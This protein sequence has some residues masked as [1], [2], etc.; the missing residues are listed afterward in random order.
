MMN[1]E[2]KTRNFVLEMMNFVSKMM[3]F[4]GDPLPFSPEG[5]GR[6]EDGQDEVSLRWVFSLSKMMLIVF[7]SE[8]MNCVLKTMNFVLKMMDIEV[9]CRAR[10]EH[11]RRYGRTLRGIH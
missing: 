2:L 10:R 7:I 9:D 11:I 1:F 3:S 6:P 4:A 5:L 8:M